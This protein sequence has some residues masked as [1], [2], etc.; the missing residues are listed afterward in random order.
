MMMRKRVQVLLSL[1][2]LLAMG[3][4][5]ASCGA[6]VDRSGEWGAYFAAFESFSDQMKKNTRFLCIDSQEVE[7]SNYQKLY[8]LFYEFCKGEKMR[9]LEGGW[10]TLYAEHLL[11]NDGKFTDGYLVS[12]SGAV[13]SEKRDTLTVTVSFR[14]STSVDTYN[15]GGTVTV[16]KT[17]GKWTARP[18]A[19]G[20]ALKGP[21]GAYLAVFEYYAENAG[22]SGLKDLLVLDPKC[23]EQEV[24]DK[25]YAGL[26]TLAAQ[27]GY[28][29]RKASWEALKSDGLIS[30]AGEFLTGY[31]I[32]YSDVE[33][34]ASDLVTM[35]CWMMQG[36]MQGLGGIFTVLWEDDRWVVT[37][38]KEMMS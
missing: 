38:V 25:V 22:M 15:F 4:T 10:S 16:S 14:S 37:N 8:D 3:L 6:K 20:S 12:F 35:T 19:E 11:T 13:W 2:L 28:T 18:R 26:R 17:D 9:L 24:E 21:E 7:G 30:E 29:C 31:Q 33:W 32:S 1:L 34:Q 36:D 27:H 5:L 23:V